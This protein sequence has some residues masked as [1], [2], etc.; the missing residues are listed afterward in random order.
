MPLY[1]FATTNLPADTIAP[2]MSDTNATAA[3]RSDTV[4]TGEDHSSGACV[5]E[6]I[7]GIYLAYLAGI[8]FL[9]LPDGKG[10]VR[11]P[12]AKISPEQKI[13]LLRVGG[14]GALV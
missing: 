5:D 8:G 6:E 7:M 3:L 12:E 4:F 10:K 9:S 11:L 13:A 14:R 1:H 2:E